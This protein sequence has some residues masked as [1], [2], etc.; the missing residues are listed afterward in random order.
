MALKGAH[1]LSDPPHR[2]HPITYSMLTQML[3]LVSHRGDHLMLTAALT[4]GF[5]GCLRSGEFCVPDADTFRP[6]IHLCM[7]DVQVNTIERSFSLR[8]KVSKTDTHS[9][10]VSIN[11]GCSGTTTC[12]YCAM[13]RFLLSR[14]D[15]KP[16]DPLFS[17]PQGNIL[18]RS[19]L[20]SAIKL[21]VSM[22]GRDPAHF[23][24][25]S[26]RAG[27]A[28]KG[29]ELGFENWEIQLMGRWSSD[30]YLLYIRNPKLLT[31]FAHRL[32]ASTK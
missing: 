1:V 11:V 32:A 13:R 16:D 25:H 6:S 29:A 22:T 19:Y 12:A 18:R 7:R 31:T 4:L 21:L 26:L 30:A 23:S 17:D 2:M 8:I 15:A 3:P 20:V 10:G 14:S 9:N 28:T 27:A 5:F 24:G